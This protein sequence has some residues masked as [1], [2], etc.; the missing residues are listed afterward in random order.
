[1]RRGLLAIGFAVAAVPFSGFVATG[2]RYAMHSHKPG[3]L[4]SWYGW[5]F[6]TASLLVTLLFVGCA[7]R[8]IGHGP[9]WQ[10]LWRT[11]VISLP[12]V[13]L[14]SLGSLQLLAGMAILVFAIWSLRRR[15]TP[16]DEP[17]TRTSRG[18]A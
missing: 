6:A 11:T 1:M 13:A 2:I 16:T 3:S 12:A 4:P 17:T 9:S 8:V 15:E 14:I 18:S 7:L 5:V 10:I